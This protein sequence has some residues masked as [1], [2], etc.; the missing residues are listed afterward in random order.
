MPYIL[1]RSLLLRWYGRCSYVHGCSIVHGCRRFKVKSMEVGLTTAFK[2]V[3]HF[4][5]IGALDRIMSYESCIGKMWF[6][7]D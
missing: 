7:F 3:F 6:H 5:E 4:R 2:R 1:S